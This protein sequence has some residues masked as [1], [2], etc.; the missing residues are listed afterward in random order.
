MFVAQVNA[1]ARLRKLH[2]LQEKIFAE[3]TLEPNTPAN[4]EIDTPKYKGG[5]LHLNKNKQIHGIPAEVWEYRVGGYQVLDKWLKSRKG[6]TMTIDDFEN[7]SSV[8]GVLTETMK[9]QTELKNR[10][11]PLKR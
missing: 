3:L 2:L 11:H 10:N 1:G 8:V 4:L 5:I 9:I 6:K 7:I